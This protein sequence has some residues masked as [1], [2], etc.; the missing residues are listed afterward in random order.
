MDRNWRWRNLEIDLI[1]L[2]D[3]T[4]VFIEVKGTDNSELVEVYQRVNTVKLKRLYKAIMA[5]LAT[6]QRKFENVRFDVIAIVKGEIHHLENVY[7]T[8]I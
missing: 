2:K 7:L 1:A 6:A 3:R 4:L 5:Y 8:D